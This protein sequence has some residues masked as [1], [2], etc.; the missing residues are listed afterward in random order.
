MK[1]WMANLDH[2]RSLD[3]E[4]PMEEFVQSLNAYNLQFLHF[5]VGGLLDRPC[6]KVLT[7]VAVLLEKVGQKYGSLLPPLAKALVAVHKHESSG[8]EDALQDL[9]GLRLSQMPTLYMSKLYKSYL[10]S[11][12]NRRVQKLTTTVMP[13]AAKLELIEDMLESIVNEEHV[14]LLKFGKTYLS[15]EGTP[16]MKWLLEDSQAFNRHTL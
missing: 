13:K 3:P 5:V 14:A 1:L 6:W 10:E 15:L 16:L 2:M 9:E 7:P 12:E 8:S 4:I 11:R